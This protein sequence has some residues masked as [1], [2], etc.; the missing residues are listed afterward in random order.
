MTDDDLLGLEDAEFDNSEFDRPTT[1]S[2]RVVWGLLI[3]LIIAVVIA[4]A[5]YISR[6]H[7]G[8]LGAVQIQDIL[9]NTHKFDG[10]TVRIKGTVT[11]SMGVFGR[12]FYRVDDGTGGIWVATSHGVPA[13]DKDVAVRGKVSTALV[14]GDQAVVG[15]VV[16]AED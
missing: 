15:I 1:T 2:S 9:D 14:I 3:L 13:K 10:E 6:G 7:V 4:A 16:S 8:P 5:L 11:D 12:G